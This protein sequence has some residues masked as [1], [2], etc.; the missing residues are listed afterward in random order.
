[1]KDNDNEFSYERQG[2]METDFFLFVVYCGLLAMFCKDRLKFEEMYSN[3]H[4]PHWYCIIGMSLQLFGIFFDLV[5]LMS[6]SKDGEG[7]PVL[8]VFGTVFDMLSECV[9]SLLILM[10][11]NGW[12]TRFKNFEFDDGIEIYGPM[13]VFVVM[14]HVV[15][16]GFTYID[17]DAYH[18][19]HDFHGWVGYCI[20][21]AK[22][23]LLAAFFYFYGYT[24]G[25]LSKQ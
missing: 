10:L 22:L 25:K 5:H 4:C 13:F 23:M 7:V 6:Y 1:M 2:A 18:K 16:G 9:M 24:V 15:F 8:E 3:I 14:I 19:Y 12:F 11:A 21:A 20:V 17:N